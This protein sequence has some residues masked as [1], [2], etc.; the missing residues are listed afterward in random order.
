MFDKDFW[1][2]FGGC[3]LIFILGVFHLWQ[4]ITAM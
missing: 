2:Y 1:I 3:L 4:I